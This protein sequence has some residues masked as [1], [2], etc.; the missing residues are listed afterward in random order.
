MTSTT[1]PGAAA[2]R[3]PPGPLARGLEFCARWLELY[4]Q[5]AAADRPRGHGDR[6]GGRDRRPARGNVFTRYVLGYSLFGADELAR[7]AFLWAIWL[8]VSLAVKR[9]AVDGD[10]HRRRRRAR[11]GGSAR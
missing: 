6:G 5:A 2:T 1:H 7:F 8:G 9:G 10:H 3:P 4:S 11:P